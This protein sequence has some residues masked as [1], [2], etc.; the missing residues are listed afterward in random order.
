LSKVE[1]RPRYLYF[2]ISAAKLRNLRK[3]IWKVK[4]QYIESI[5][6][7]NKEILMKSRHGHITTA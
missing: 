4:E 3:S 7:P 6:E 5:P 2:G 1:T